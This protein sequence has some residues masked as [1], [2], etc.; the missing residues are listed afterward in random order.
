M[1][2]PQE[3]LDQGIAKLDAL[4]VE[5]RKLQREQRELEQNL[6]DVKRAILSGFKD[7]WPTDSHKL[8]LVSLVVHG[9]RHSEFLFLPYVNGKA[10]VELSQIDAML[11]VPEGSTISIG[12]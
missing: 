2:S 7:S 6:R 10:H 4:D 12:A 8:T 5:I 3:T 9:V 1:L 11:H